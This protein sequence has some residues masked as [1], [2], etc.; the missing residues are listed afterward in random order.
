MAFPEDFTDKCDRVVNEMLQ[1]KQL[2]PSRQLMVQLTPDNS[3]P[4]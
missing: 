1:I 4:R 3:N 2:S